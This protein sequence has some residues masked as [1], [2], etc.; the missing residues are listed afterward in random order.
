VSRGGEIEQSYLRAM[1]ETLTAGFTRARERLAGVTTLS[2][3]NLDEALG[4][5]RRSLL[6]A[7]VDYGVVKDFLERVRAKSVGTRVETKVRDAAGRVHRVTP[8]QHFVAVCEEELAALMGPVDSSLAARDG[9][10]SVLLLGLQGVG[11]T[12][13]AAKLARRLQKQGR[14]PLLVAADVQRPAAVEQLQ[15]LGASIDVAVHAGAPGEAPPSLC[16]RAR[17]RARDAGFDAIVYDTAGRLAIDPE[18]MAELRAVAAA[19]EPANTLLVCDALMGRDAVNVARAFAEQLRVDGVILT[20]LDGDARGGAALA[21]KAVT[22]VPIKWVGTGESVDRLEEFRPEGLATRILGMGDVVGLVRDFE[23]VVDA[24][25]AEADAERLLAGRFGMEDL[26]AQLR[27]L[28]KMGPLRD[29]LGK[30]PGLGEMAGQVDEREL[31]KTQA[32]IQSM[33]PRERQRPELIDRSRAARIARGSGRS[34]REVQDLVARF[35][36]MRELMGALGGGGGL[37]GK[38]P[39]MGRLAGAGPGIPSGFD[40]AALLGGGGNRQL[41]RQLE[42]R[43]KSDAKKKR[44]QAKAAR[45]KS[46]RR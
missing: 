13:V 34:P 10:V 41:R 39:G 20:K 46:R 15:R 38:I 8:G 2:D 35:R 37:L 6:E 23:E 26:L 24:R 27:T 9:V 28:Q 42:A 32:M 18:L 25:Q 40:P 4:E 19:A 22:G 33:T 3:A 45:R 29:V 43:Q 30:L 36:Q 17:E 31:V 11:K 14:R 21:V 1:L 44:K 12:T 5:V 7:D 16:T